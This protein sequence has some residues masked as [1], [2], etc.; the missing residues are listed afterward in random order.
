MN[1][2]KHDLSVFIGSAMVVG[3]L[4]FHYGFEAGRDEPAPIAEPG[5]DDFLSQAEVVRT[6]VVPEPLTFDLALE[7]ELMARTS[8]DIRTLSDELT[9][10]LQH[11]EF[12]FVNE[13][14][15]RMAARAVEAGDEATLGGA[16]SLLGQLALEEQDFDSA[17][18]YLL[19]SLDVYEQL[20]D[21]VGAA[22][23]NMHLGRMHVRL[24]Q[25][26][27]TAGYAYDRVLL[28][29]T[30]LANGA[31]DAAEQNLRLVVDENLSIN[32]FGAAASAYRSL[33]R[34][35][36]EAGLPYEAE[37]AAIEAAELYAAAGQIDNAQAVVTSLERAGVEE[38]RLLDIEEAVELRFAEFTAS[39][40]QIERAGDYRRL[41]RYYRSQGEEDR[42]WRLRLLASKSLRNVSKRAMY[43]RIP[44]V[45]ALLYVSNDDKARAQTYLERAA[46][47]FDRQ[48]HDDLLSQTRRLKGQIL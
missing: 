28:A 14:L 34:L 23:V 46:T 13:H 36:G 27:R 29:R 7:Q 26:A 5:A 3:V 30:Q 39:V 48:G 47:V 10:L 42:A 35:Y 16:L 11:E 4:A 21:T 22:Q 19:E 45:L 1:L 24:R 2:R 31:H 12:R 44:D 40:E 17:E 8:V 15:L 32:R 25:R 6:N 20:G 9:E 37:Q 33:I 18:V 41:Y 43:R 38:W